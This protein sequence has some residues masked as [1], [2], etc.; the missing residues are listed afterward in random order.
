MGKRFID[1]VM[2]AR[3]AMLAVVAMVGCVIV[4]ASLDPDAFGASKRYAIVTTASLQEIGAGTKTLREVLK[5]KNPARDAQALLNALTPAIY[6]A[7]D[8]SANFDLV[9]E[10]V[11]LNH[12][13]YKAAEPDVARMMGVGFYTAK[14]YKFI[15]DKQK[16]AA[17]AKG[18]GVDGVLFVGVNFGLTRHAGGVFADVT[19]GVN[20]YDRQGRVV[21]RDTVFTRSNKT[22]GVVQGAV[23]VEGVVPLLVQA[24]DRGASAMVAKLGEKL[25]N[26]TSGFHMDPERHR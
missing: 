7:L 11:V 24:T 26:G 10:K 25:A 6:A 14:G 12:R 20:A 1:I 3:L 13:A 8:K 16:L 18:L 5:G 23:S 15:K 22:V 9:P 19:F 17:L 4:P 2:R 21:W